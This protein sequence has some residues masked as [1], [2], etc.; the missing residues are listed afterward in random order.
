[1]ITTYGFKYFFML[2]VVVTIL[3][4]EGWIKYI[5][6]TT[7]IIKNKKLIPTA[8]MPH[9]QLTSH[10]IHQQHHQNSYP[11]LTSGLRPR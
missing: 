11:Q 8:G 10:Q 3:I 2:S 1:M 4:I 9:Q 5:K 6:T 7:I